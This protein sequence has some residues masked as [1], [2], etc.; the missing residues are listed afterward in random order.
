MSLFQTLIFPETNTYSSDSSDIPLEFYNLVFPKSAKVDMVL[1]YFSTNAI[2]TL[3]ISFSEFIYNG[4]NLRIV[5]NHF[6]SEQDKEELLVNPS[7]KDANRVFNIFSDLSTL[8]EELGPYGRHFFDCLKYLIKAGRLEIQPV[9]HKPD[10]LAHYKKIIFFDGDQHLYLHGSANFTQAGIIKNGESFIVDRSWGE[11]TEKLRVEREILNFERIFN[12][13]HEAFDYLAPEQVI[14]IINSIGRDS[15]LS[16]LLERAITLFDS[17]EVSN[18]VKEIYRRKQEEFSEKIERLK[19]DPKFPYLEGP[20]DYQ[21]KAY[22]NWVKN[23]CQGLFAMATGT[24]KTITSLNCILEEY[25]K[26]KQYRFIVLVPTIA[27]AEQ[28]F[29]ELNDPKGFN[30]RNAYIC[31]SKQ[32]DWEGNLSAIG[33]NLTFGNH[34]NFCFV[35]TYASFR[36][37][38]FQNIWNRAL[39]KHADSITLIADEA[40][41]MGS[42]ELLKVLPHQ[43]RKRIGLSATPERVYDRSGE[44]ELCRFF[45]S[46]P[47]NYTFVYNMQRAI[48]DKILC[49]YFYYPEIVDLGN[50]ELTEYK[51]LTKKLAKF[52]DPATGRYRDIKQANDLLM[53]RKNIIHKAANK[54]MCLARIIRR[55]GPEKFKYAFIY[56]PEGNVAD[57]TETDIMISDQDDEKII[58]R[59]VSLLYNEFGLKMRKFLGSTTDRDAILQQFSRG[60]LDAILAMKCLDEGV[61]IPRTQYAIFCSSTGNP[62][63]YVQRRGRVLRKIEGKDYAY[64]YDMVVKTPLDMSVTNNAEKKVEKNILMSELKRLINFAALAENKLEIMQSLED[65]AAHYEIDIYEMMNTELDSYAI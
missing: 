6:L 65:L 21:R 4:G 9:M 43:I 10:A 58:K 41:T 25:K 14:G 64:I 18:K 15:D 61:D 16:E 39:V 49:R 5:T 46:A 53:L 45:S 47:P 44:F 29:K 34:S 11:K 24:G 28:W 12:K 55:V 13:E 1:G 3:A 20:R 8:S 30:F 56:V 23:N 7:L 26:Y 51:S 36:G 32:K 48:E 35:I 62:R 31:S 57:Y 54:E 22:D 17:E 37:K 27:L 38:K 33:I 52:I 2:R 50:D 19:M 60:E 59:Y 42:G 63:Q 40:H